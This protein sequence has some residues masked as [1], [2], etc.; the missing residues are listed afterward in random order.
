M[1]DDT[2]APTIVESA[3]TGPVKQLEAINFQLLAQQLAQP[4]PIK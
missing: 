3:D 4:S 2:K 1:E